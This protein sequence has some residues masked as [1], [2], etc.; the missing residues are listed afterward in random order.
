MSSSNQMRTA[1]LHIFM[2]I[3]KHTTKHFQM[4]LGSTLSLILQILKHF[5][6]NGKSLNTIV[7]NMDLIQRSLQKI[8]KKLLVSAK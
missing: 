1:K 2:V 8:L 4:T 7:P 3:S 6:E 5:K